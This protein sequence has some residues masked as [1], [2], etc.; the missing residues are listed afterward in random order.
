LNNSF[1]FEY[2]KKSQ[3]RWSKAKVEE[4]VEVEEKKKKREE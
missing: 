4:V 3:V 1:T 2:K